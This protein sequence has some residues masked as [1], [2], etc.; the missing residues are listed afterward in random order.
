MALGSNQS[1]QKSH[2]RIA[3]INQ[4][5]RLIFLMILNVL[6]SGCQGKE[7]SGNYN[8][9]ISIISVEHLEPLIRQP[10]HVLLEEKH[11]GER[12]ARVMFAHSE[13]DVIAPLT[14]SDLAK[15][16][17]K[18]QIPALRE[19]PFELYRI[20]RGS[21]QCFQAHSHYRVEVCF[22]E[23]SF[24]LDVTLRAAPRIYLY[25]TRFDPEQGVPFENPKSFTIAEAID[26]AL[27]GNPDIQE[28]RER[29][30][31]AKQAARAAYFELVP[32]VG[33]DTGLVLAGNLSMMPVSPVGLAWAVGDFA[34]F[35]FPGRWLR[36]RTLKWEGRAEQ[37]TDL[38]LRANTAAAVQALAVHYA[39]WGE[40]SMRLKAL[41][42]FIEKVIARLLE[43]EKQGWRQN[44]VI[45]RSQ[46]M[47]ANLRAELGAVK[48]SR[49]SDQRALSRILGFKN[50]H[51]VGSI[52]IG[53]E[54]ERIEKLPILSDED[55]LKVQREYAQLALM[56]SFEIR[57]L[58]FLKRAERLNEKALFVNWMD[59]ESPQSIGINLIPQFR[60]QRSVRK[61]LNIKLDRTQENLTNQA[62]SV[63]EARNLLIS[64]YPIAKESIVLREKMLFEEITPIFEDPSVIKLWDADYVSDR[65]DAM[66]MGIKL[67]YNAHA[68]VLMN[69]AMLD[70]IALQGPYERLIRFLQISPDPEEA[71]NKKLD[72]QENMDKNRKKSCFCFARQEE[73]MGKE[74]QKK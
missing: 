20:K 58:N 47:A 70:R 8:G 35:F 63:V 45:G 73:K 27:E 36:A 61:T 51:A 55:L 43:L 16:H 49:N 64:Y 25:G 33:M 30:F 42:T 46:I 56:N 15:D 4:M 54:L 7:F 28:E 9:N 53:D 6:L 52:I 69:Q 65:V 26:K 50:P 2:F 12:I 11:H 17:F 66:M 34:P 14:L 38:L 37:M 48:A 29:L 74:L 67:L 31:Q 19:E 32:H 57:Q 41:L 5:P 60:F 22:D 21:S 62:F 39:L 71:E 44:F 59:I 3:P 10:V 40:Q 18:L 72:V 23:N 24:V 1:L 13:R 68:G